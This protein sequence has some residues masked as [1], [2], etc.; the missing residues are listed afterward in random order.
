MGLSD[1]SI[2]NHSFSIKHERTCDYDLCTSR[3][4]YSYFQSVLCC[5]AEMGISLEIRDNNSHNDTFY[6]FISN[7]E[8]IAQLEDESQKRIEVSK[9]ERDFRR[10]KKYRVKADYYHESITKEEYDKIKLIY[11]KLISYQ[12]C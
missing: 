6:E 5:L 2:K 3:L 11:Q 10:F 9:A 12:N 8:F 1:K 7:I 4:Y